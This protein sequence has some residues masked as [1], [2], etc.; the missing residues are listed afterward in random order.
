MDPVQNFYDKTNLALTITNALGFNFPP[1]FL[2]SKSVVK[3]SH[4]QISP[5]EINSYSFI[6]PLTL[7]LD[8]E[9]EGT[10]FKL[11]LDPIISLSCKNIIKRRYVAKSGKN[12]NRGSIKETWST[13]DYD[14][15]ISG[16]FINEDAALLEQNL[17]SLRTYCESGES[18]HVT[19]GLLLDVYNIKRIVIESFD[20]PH[21]PGVEN[22]AFTIKAYSD[23]TYQL[24][25]DL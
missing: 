25:E 5:Q 4:G 18:I 19:C 3:Y 11:P 7:R 20:F 14:I 9:A 21:T 16:V 6:V 13:D 22:Q 17:R 10:G 12:S 1:P 8:T 15:Q 24:L 2:F 23:E